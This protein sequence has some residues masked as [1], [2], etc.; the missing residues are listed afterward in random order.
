MAR[1]SD[2]EPSRRSV[3]RLLGGVAGA[4]VWPLNFAG[5]DMQGGPVSV[6]SFYVP[7]P[8]APLTPASQFYI[9]TNYYTPRVPSRWELH[10]QG[11]VDDRLTLTLDDLLQMP[12]VTREVT[13]ECIGNIPGGSL[14]SSAP[15]TG[16]PLAAVLDRAGAS[17]RARG[18][19]LLGLDGYPAYVPISV[20]DREDALLVHQ[21]HGEPLTADH[22]APLRALLPG[23]F[24]M[25][26]IKWLDSITL[27]REYA[28]YGSLSELVNF[29][30]GQT[31]VRSRI[32]TLFD[33]SEVPLG[34]PVQVRG[35]AV[36]PGEGITRVQVHTGTGWRDAML[37]FNT[38]E[39]AISPWLWTLWSF[40]WTP[41]TAGERVVQVRAFQP[42][43]TTQDAEADFPYD[44]SAIHRVVVRVR[45]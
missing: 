22:G 21:L 3:I 26:S 14:I 16:V 37:T 30:D 38:L 33:G 36:T 44:G 13:L 27:T 19:Q 2:R 28:T 45:G 20:A 15:F 31:R 7:T 29:I 43:G 24:G 34:V 32:D 5:C 1:P 18:I 23:R 6:G 8:D 17:D 10:V 41:E 40:E 11:L 4:G 9:N 12:Q 25:F 42:D 35:L 39:D